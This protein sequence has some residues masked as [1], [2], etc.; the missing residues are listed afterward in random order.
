MT[1]LKTMLADRAQRIL[2]WL[3]LKP[4]GQQLCTEAASMWVTSARLLVIVMASAEALSWG[5]LGYFV[6]APQFSVPAA[7]FAA[8]SI[9]VLVWVVDSSFMTLDIARSFYERTFLGAEDVPDL[10][11]RAKWVGGVLFRVIVVGGSLSITAPYVAQLI[12]KTDIEGEIRRINAGKIDEGRKNAT[13]DI[14]AAIKAAKAEVALRENQRV[15]ESEG[16]GPSKKYGRGPAVETI[17]D[18]LVNAKQTLAKLQQERNKLVDDYNETAKDERLLAKK[19][20]VS[21]DN[22]GLQSRGKAMETLSANS[23]YQSAQ[24][25]IKGFLGFLFIAMLIL[26]A[27][28]PR[29]IRI[30]Y[31]E[32]MQDLFK[33]YMAGSLNRY[34]AEEERPLD[35]KPRMAPLR[36]EEWAL[37]SYASTLDRDRRRAAIGEVSER[38]HE[39]LE[40]LKKVEEEISAEIEPL[41]KALKE[42]R[43]RCA[44]TE[45]GFRESKVGLDGVKAKL[46]GHSRGQVALE[47]VAKG[48]RTPDQIRM[49]FR[50]Q[51][52]FR[53]TTAELESTIRDREVEA[54]RLEKELNDVRAEM[55]R[56]SM[57]LETRE[58][59][60][61]EVRAEIEHLR[62]DYAQRLRS[63]D[64]PRS[65]AASAS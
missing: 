40:L 64:P 19:Y 56:L 1:N 22:F 17:E 57:A 20:G 31:S 11:E 62:R 60:L 23:S 46:D 52:A 34:L 26:K 37:H 51:D 8:L 61:G 49:L 28:Q 63:D 43:A 35:G 13:Q 45:N 65:S 3:S 29:S 47:D 27:F 25:A 5:Y 41:E 21:L 24:W 14:D 53:S 32:Q 36:F 33:Q 7:L 54:S 30:Y 38:Y 4:Y 58:V 9:M 39:K 18:A 16:V 48:E 2:A 55:K 6:G 42:L 12:F 50:V 59:S 44:E 10:K 15:A